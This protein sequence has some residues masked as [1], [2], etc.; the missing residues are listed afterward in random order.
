VKQSREKPR[1]ALQA[2]PGKQTSDRLKTYV[3]KRDFSRTSEP[4]PDAEAGDGRRFVVQKHDARRLHYDLRLELNGV[5][6]SWAVPNGPSYILAEKRLAVRTEDHP[7][8]YLSFEGT[9]P[10]GEYGGGA[11]IVWDRG[12]WAPVHDVHKS[13]A[14]G[15][16]EF[17]LVG[18]R[19]KGR[20]HLVRIKPRAREKTEPWLLIKADDAYARNASDP[21]ILETET[22][23]VLTGRSTG[24][25][26][27]QQAI[28]PDHQQRALISG[29]RAAKAPDPRKIKGARK[30]LLPLF[31]EPSLASPAERPPPGSQWRHEIKFDGYRIQARIDA[32]EIRLLTRT[33][34]D[35]TER[36]PGIAEAVRKL[37]LGS[38]LLD[39]EI[40]VEDE[41]GISSFNDLI[42]D[43]K[44]GRQDRFRYYLFDL[45]YLDGSDLQGAVLEKRKEALAAVLASAPPVDRIVLSEHFDVEGAVLFEHVSRLGLEGIISKRK[46]APYRSGRVKEWVKCKCIRRQEFVIAGYVPSTT[47]R[48]MVGSLVLGYYE[49]RKFTHAGRA[50]SGFAQDE[51]AALVEG[52][53]QTRIDRPPFAGKLTPEASKGVRWVEPRLVAEV[54]FAGWSA[55]GVLRHT[56]FRGLREDRNPS[57]IVRE[58]RST[59]VEAAPTERFA[60]TS[61]DRMLWPDEGVTKQG[62][63]DFYAEIAEWIMP[64]LT[65]RPLSL[66]RCPGGIEEACFYAKHEWAGLGKSVRR[67]EA[68]KEAPMLVIDS[69]EGLL[70]FVQANVLEIHPWGS[71][72]R[73]LER[74]DQLIFDLD[75]GEGVTWADVIEGAIEVRERLRSAYKLESF[76][77]TSGGK[78]LHVVVPLMPTLEWEPAKALCKAVADA[79]A[80]DWPRRYIARATKSARDGRIFVDYLRNGRGATA[81][82]AYSTRARA[83]AA[84]ST[85]L[86]WEELS[87]AIKADHFRV[88]N[89]G[90]RLAFL[91]RDPWADYFTIKQ[92]LAAPASRSRANRGKSP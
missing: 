18:E 16:L 45:L 27:A 28:R 21:D 53:E 81:V 91:Q 2:E 64:H 88:G 47:S 69:L 56:T 15:H 77:K 42:G 50:G 62:L 83:G 86:G 5:L 85:P 67:V 8:K 19:L 29:A 23:S 89:L 76:V 24:D 10:K 48:R 12:T 58:D 61:P 36:F 71:T 46:D 82:A 44:S 70:E 26:E 25:L 9:I 43:L 49:G 66:V 65:G 4:G 6:L 87:E 14:K 80:A 41:R 34:L 90:R 30:A 73:D 38:A 75:P 13:L 72:M 17:E 68:G 22:T 55:D 33:G 1:S 54:E 20:W 35:W 78:G 37:G 32:G 57:E 79:M 92:R 51:A 60:L 59:T 74:P 39:G 31:V 52:L 84:V 7:L 40:V 63:A 3:G 11:M